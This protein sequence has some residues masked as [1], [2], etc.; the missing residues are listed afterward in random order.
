[1]GHWIGYAARGHEIE[2][3][4]AIRAIGMSAWVAKRI[5]W[6]RNPTGRRWRAEVEPLLP[7]YVFIECTD[8]Q[9][10]HLRDVK[11][12]ATTLMGIS[13]QSAAR[14]LAPFREKVDAAF[15]ESQD[16]AKAREMAEVFTPGEMIELEKGPLAGMLVTFRRMVETDKPGFPK[17][18]AGVTLFG[19]EGEIEVDPINVKRV[20]A[21]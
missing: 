11:F 21:V 15:T 16:K 5:E 9:W 10:H 20:A 8:D 13:R 18:I 19:K 6:R 17:L 3:E 7:N 1:M 14:Y 12:L 2:V 4:D